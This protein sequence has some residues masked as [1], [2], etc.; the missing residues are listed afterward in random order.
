MSRS[1]ANHHRAPTQATHLET[2]AI[3]GPLHDSNERPA[4]GV[5]RVVSDAAQRGP[6]AAD[7]VDTAIMA[8]VTVA[9]NLRRTT[10]VRCP[11]RVL[12]ERGNE[13]PG[14]AVDRAPQ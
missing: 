4:L 2:F 7:V 11:K 6:S 8:R 13:Q 5:L 1:R 14:R 3:Y 12:G 9:G 10:L